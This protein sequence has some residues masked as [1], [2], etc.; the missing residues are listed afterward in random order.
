MHASVQHTVVDDRVAAIAGR[1]EHFQV[2]PAGEGLIGELA[3]VDFRHDHIGKQQGDARLYFQHLQG[4][5]G[6]VGFQDA[7]TQL[8][9]CIH[10]H[11]AHGRLVLHHKNDFL[12]LATRQGTNE[13]GGCTL[14][15]SA[16][17]AGQ[18]NLHGGATAHLR[19]DLHMPAGLLDEAIHLGEPQ[20]RTATHFL[21]SKKRI[22]GLVN[23]LCG[24][25]LSG[26]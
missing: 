11:L 19:V 13:G 10:R 26:V 24:H 22:E 6:P 3:S 17:Q 21:G 4:G 9:Q 25:A 23:D 1:E 8:S 18:I 15:R 7:I 5:R 12:R 2:R 20:T 14:G 16:L